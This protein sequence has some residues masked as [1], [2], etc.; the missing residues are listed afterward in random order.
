METRDQSP[1]QDVTPAA[2]APEIPAAAPRPVPPPVDR[3]AAHPP[4]GEPPSFWKVFRAVLF[5]GVAVTALLLAGRRWADA[6]ARYRSFHV[7]DPGPLL[8]RPDA[9]P[10]AVPETPAVDEV[11]AKEPRNVV[12]HLTAPAAK[13]VLLG[14]SFNNFDARE[15]PLTRRPDGVWEATL[16]LPPGRYLYKFKVDGRWTLDP[17]NPERRTGDREASILDIQ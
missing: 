11:A 3:R 4:T 8:A 12:F 14:G 10:A 15:A 13:A 1:R 16:P 5:L 9:A 2:P 6:Y 7:Y 17:A